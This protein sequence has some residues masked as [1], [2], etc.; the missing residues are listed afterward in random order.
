MF[1]FDVAA[2]S[3]KRAAAEKKAKL[4]EIKPDKS[5]KAR[6]RGEKLSNVC[7]HKVR[8]TLLAA[9]I[10]ASF[11][12]PTRTFAQISSHDKDRVDAKPKPV[13]LAQAI[14]Q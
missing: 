9:G 2:R 12:I 10:V 13:L 3:E 4:D 11:L 14:V 6:I 8:N 7:V 5:V 1:V